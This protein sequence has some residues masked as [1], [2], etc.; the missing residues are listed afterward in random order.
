METI[1]KKGK[2]LLVRKIKVIDLDK[3]KCSNKFLSHGL[4]DDTIINVKCL[5]DGEFDLRGRKE[6]YRLIMPDKIW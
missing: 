2:A 3:S 5:E 6:E 4:S 1:I